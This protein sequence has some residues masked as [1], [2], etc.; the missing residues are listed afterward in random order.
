[1]FK[2]SIL[3]LSTVTSIMDSASTDEQ[4]RAFGKIETPVSSGCSYTAWG[5][6]G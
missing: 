2:R 5:P 6:V 3:F 4:Y 1:M